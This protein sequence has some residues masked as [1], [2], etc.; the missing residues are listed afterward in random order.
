MK[1]I[2]TGDETTTD[3]GYPVKPGREILGAAEC[4]EILADGLSIEQA[5]EGLSGDRWIRGAV[6]AGEWEIVGD[7]S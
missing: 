4:A 3:H 5:I 2:Y 1:V 6:M 7:E